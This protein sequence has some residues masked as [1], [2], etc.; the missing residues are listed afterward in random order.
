M[1]ATVWFTPTGVFWMTSG[2]EEPTQWTGRVEDFLAVLVQADEDLLE[3]ARLL[4]VPAEPWEDGG[5]CPD[6]GEPKRRL[7]MTVD[8]YVEVCD[9]HVDRA[10]RALGVE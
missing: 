9:C 2:D 8:R 5:H 6:C 7:T 4:V 3:G 1:R 10:E